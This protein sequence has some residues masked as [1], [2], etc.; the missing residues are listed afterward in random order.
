V[1]PGLRAPSGP[2]YSSP[3]LVQKEIRALLA[4]ENPR[5]DLIANLFLIL[6]GPV[7][8]DLKRA[9]EKELVEGNAAGVQQ[10]YRAVQD[11]TVVADLL[12]LLDVTATDERDRAN[13]AYVLSVLPGGD[14]AEVTRGL[15]ARLTG[16]FEKDKAFL[17]AIARRGGSEAARALVEVVAKHPDPAKLPAETWFELDLSD[18]PSAAAYLAYA[19]KDATRPPEVLRRI[20]E[21]AGR[22]GGGAAVEAL[23]ALAA[24]GKPDALRRQ[25]LTSLGLVGDERAIEH[26]LAVA[27]KGADS[28]SVAAR[29]LSGVS[30]APVPSRDRLLAVARD[31]KDDFLKENVVTALGSLGEK[32]ALPLL[33][34]YAATGS[35]AV[36]TAAVRAIGRMGPAASAHVDALATA[37]SRGSDGMRCTVVEALAGVR[38]PEALGV[39]RQ[40]SLGDADPRVK[41]SIQAALRAFPPSD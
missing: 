8:A 29:A 3:E 5:W 10:A 18:D 4:D 30:S 25:A 7:D 13:V 14:A 33:V 23:T 31:T 36:R 6:K 35:E 16:D 20:A 39:L 24:E 34:E 2:D 32:R 11:P 12:R 37:Y 21:M 15:E 26:L 22:L 9:L 28:A 27:E 38:T 1:T 19:L 17:Q 41:R 40:L